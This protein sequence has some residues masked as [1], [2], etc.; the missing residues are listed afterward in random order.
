MKLLLGND[1]TEVVCSS[2]WQLVLN[3]ECGRQSAAKNL[4]K[5]ENK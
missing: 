1:L 2:S 4:Y 3:T 5:L